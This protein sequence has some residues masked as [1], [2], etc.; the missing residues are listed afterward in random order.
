[1]QSYIAAGIDVASTKIITCVGKWD[2]ANPDIVGIGVSE[3]Q[4]IRKGVIVDIEETVSAISASL[5]EAERMSGVPVS[6]AVVGLTGSH[7]ESEE[8][9][10]IIAINKPDGEIT[11]E[12]VDRA[13]EAARAIAS[14]P[15]RHILHV[16]PKTFVIDGREETKD[17]VGLT[18]MRLEV[19]ANIVTASVGAVK[20]LTRAIDQAGIGVAE[21]VFSPLASAGLILSKRQMEIGVILVDIGACSTSYVVYEEGEVL[22]CGVIP[23]GSSHITNDIAIGLRTNIDLA[24]KIKVKFGYAVPDKVNEREEID[25]SKLDKGET[26]TAEAKYIAEIIEA[27]LNE[28]FLIIK[29][30]LSNLSLSGNLPAGVVL[31]G[32]GAKIEGILDLVKETLHLP[33][34]VGKPIVEI[35]GLIDK[36]DDPV[37]AT[38]IGLMLMGK[39]KLGGG[40]SFDFNVDNLGGVIERVRSVLK[41]FLP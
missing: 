30:N 7:I 13:L 39:H 28:I 38:S 5:E 37:Y 25:F 32:G 41:H 29:N 15:N 26:G 8:V 17:P 19:I 24:E 1:M 9:N 22:H 3:N 40:T 31:S 36:I 4:G 27:R 6:L 18:G 12:D 23:I 14:K 34:Q 20:T 33:A 10:G 16:L 2:G 11:K 35:S 21:I